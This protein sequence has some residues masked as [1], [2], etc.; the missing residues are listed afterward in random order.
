MVI[1]QLLL[2][3]GVANLDLDQVAVQPVGLEVAAD[4]RTLRSPETYL[5]HDRA[6]GLASPDGLWADTPH[7]YTP[8]P[9]LGLNEWAPAGDWAISGRAATATAAGARLSMRFQA[10]DVNLVMGPTTRGAAIP[11]RVTLDGGAV[12]GGYGT[13]V[14]ADGAGVVNEQRTYQLIRQLAPI[15]ERVFEIEFLEPGADLYCF[16][17]G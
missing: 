15:T 2:E 16:T 7:D 8:P 17:F 9:G 13:D 3:A 14:T 10:R 6:S 4:Y 1:Q 11:F 5:G 12:S